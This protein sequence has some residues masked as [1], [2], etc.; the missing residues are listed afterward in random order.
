[1]S[2]SLSEGSSRMPQPLWLVATE[3]DR[4]WVCVLCS[5]PAGGTAS[6]RAEARASPPVRLPGAGSYKSLGNLSLYPTGNKGPMGGRL[7][8]T[9]RQHAA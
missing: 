4:W 9:A 3:L 5:V 1:M 7:P 2:H 8:P 6:C